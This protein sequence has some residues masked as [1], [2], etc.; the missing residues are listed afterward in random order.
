LEGAPAYCVKTWSPP[1]FPPIGRATVLC[2]DIGRAAVLCKDIAPKVSIRSLGG[3]T[4][5]PSLLPN[6]DLLRA[7]SD[8][9]LA[10]PRRGFSRLRWVGGGGL[11][12]GGGARTFGRR[13]QREL[14]LQHADDLGR[15]DPEVSLQLLRRQLERTDLQHAHGRKW[16]LRASRRQ[17]AACGVERSVARQRNTERGLAARR[18]CAKPYRSY[19]RIAS[20]FLSKVERLNMGTPFARAK[21]TTASTSA[22]PTPLPRLSAAT[23]IRCS[24]SATTS[25]VGVR[26]SPRHMQQRTAWSCPCGALP[27]S[28]GHRAG[29]IL[30]AYHPGVAGSSH[31]PATPP[32]PRPQPTPLRRSHRSAALPSPQQK[33]R[34]QGGGCKKTQCNA[35]HHPVLSWW[36]RT[37]S[38][39]APPRCPRPHTASALLGKFPAHA[40][41]LLDGTDA[42]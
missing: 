30:L 7:V 17:S 21:P 11:L 38:P 42:Q 25:A 24:P 22:P 16:L 20:T 31:A 9:V 12:I 29:S 14:K 34:G 19:K 35:Y 18:T 3:S 39:C 37:S 28:G 27:Y 33:T 15:L 2:Q 5:L 41:H 13:I 8:P 6:L 23:D 40:L 32:S 10:P 26:H 4:L 36:R 1:W